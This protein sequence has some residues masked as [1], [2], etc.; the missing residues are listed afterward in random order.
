MKFCFIL[1]K[2]RFVLWYLDYK[3]RPDWSWSA[4]SHLHDVYQV[5]PWGKRSGA[6]PEPHNP[7]SAQVQERIDLYLHSATVASWQVIGRTLPWSC[8]L[9]GKFQRSGRK[10]CLHVN[11]FLIQ[12]PYCILALRKDKAV[13]SY[14][15]YQCTRLQAGLTTQ[16]IV[17]C[18]LTAVPFLTNGENYF[19]KFYH[20][21]QAKHNTYLI[22]A[23]FKYYGC[24]Q[25]FFMS[26]NKQYAA[27]NGTGDLRGLELKQ[28]QLFTYN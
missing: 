17:G 19:E 9:V 24:L 16:K 15:W 11:C 22:E 21:E 27:F 5:I 20:S 18:T 8:S 23:N 25:E 3:T 26:I 6:W 14:Y 28:W 4:C 10:E 12:M 7:Y 13:C 2:V 1:C